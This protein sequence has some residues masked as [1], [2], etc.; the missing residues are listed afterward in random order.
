MPS[1]DQHLIHLHALLAAAG[2]GL[3]GLSFVVDQFAIAV[4]AIH[5]YEDAALGVGNPAAT[6]RPAESAEHLV[7]DDAEAGAGQH[8]DR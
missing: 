3:I 1:P 5:G 6:C 4:V 7:V 8:G 2:D